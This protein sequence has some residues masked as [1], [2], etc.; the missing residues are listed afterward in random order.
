MVVQR[1]ARQQWVIQF[2]LIVL[3]TMVMIVWGLF[4]LPVT[5]YYLS[6]NNE[7]YRPTAAEC[8]E[9]RDFICETE[10]KKAADLLTLTGRPPL[11]DCSTFGDEG[12]E[13]DYVSA[14]GINKTACKIECH[15]YFYCENNFCKP[16]CDRFTDH[17]ISYNRVSDALMITSACVGFLSGMGVLAVFLLRRKSLM[18]FPTILV[19]YTTV[20]VLYVEVVILVSFMNQLRLFC[21]SI[22]LVE[23]FDRPTAYCKFTGVVES[24]SINQGILWWFFNICAIFWKVQ[25]PFHAR[26]YMTRPIKQSTST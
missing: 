3:M 23:S 14:I 9:I 12:L 21:S 15:E 17:P 4:S 7:D 8:M 24:Y 16:R 25:F 11:P 6:S 5:F 10:W 22:D 2:E 13:C 1:K 19:L 20:T 18:K 26:Y